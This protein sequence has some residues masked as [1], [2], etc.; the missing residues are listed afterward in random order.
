MYESGVSTSEGKQTGRIYCSMKPEGKNYS[1]DFVKINWHTVFATA[2]FR[3]D[4]NNSHKKEFDS[5]AKYNFGLN[6]QSR[7]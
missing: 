4:L 2:K 6:S 7:H 3:Y 1:L 5:F